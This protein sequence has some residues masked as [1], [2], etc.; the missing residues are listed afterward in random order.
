[1]I[2]GLGIDVVHTQRLRRWKRIPGLFERFYHPQ[3]LRQCLARGEAS[4][5]LSLAARFAAKEAFGKA[6][7]SGL[8]GFSLREI[9]VMNDERGKPIMHLHGD[10]A[11]ELRRIG[12]ERVHISPSHEK[13]N[14]LAVVIIEAD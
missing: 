7:G 3:E 6:L 9:A 10:A 11:R 1:M 14:S 2:I 4:G 12:G 13:D 5:L 8:K